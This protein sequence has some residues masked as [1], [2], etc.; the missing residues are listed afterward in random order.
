MSEVIAI[1][2]PKQLKKEFIELNPNYAED[3]RA[4]I[5]LDVKKKKLRQ[6]LAE[7]D[8]FRNEIGK[9]TGITR[10]GAEIIREDRDHGH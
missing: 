2:I 7:L 8:K 6:T 3:L 4:Y 9:K 5:E 10:S 1:R